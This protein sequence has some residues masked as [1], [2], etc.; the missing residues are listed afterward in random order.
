MCANTEAE[1]ISTIVGITP[2]QQVLKLFYYI[3]SVCFFL[4][5]MPTRDLLGI[6][7]PVLFSLINISTITLYL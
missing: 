6:R 4:L 2:H 5:Q 1:I 7:M 3:P